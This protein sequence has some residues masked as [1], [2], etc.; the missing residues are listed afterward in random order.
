MANQRKVFLFPFFFLNTANLFFQPSFAD[1][2][3]QI[4]TSDGFSVHSGPSRCKSPYAEDDKPFN[5][6]Y[7]RSFFSLPI[8]FHI[9]HRAKRVTTLANV[10]IRVQTCLPWIWRLLTLPQ[11]CTLVVIFKNYYS[12]SILVLKRND[13]VFNSLCSA[14]L[15]AKPISF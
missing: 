1:E 5:L 13:A 8:V 12:A 10:R 14:F 15:F 11:I 3:N 2:L 6:F 9:P 7:G 4:V